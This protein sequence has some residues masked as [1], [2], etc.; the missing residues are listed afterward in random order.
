MLS[1]FTENKWELDLNFSRKHFRWALGGTFY[2]AM[3]VKLI[4]Q[5]YKKKA[6]VISSEKSLYEWI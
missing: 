4:L 6:H 2:M 5:Y 3:D 1:I